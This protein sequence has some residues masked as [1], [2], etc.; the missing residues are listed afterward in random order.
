MHTLWDKPRRDACDC[1]IGALHSRELSLVASAVEEGASRRA[2]GEQHK[3]VSR[4]K[5]RIYGLCRRTS[6]SLARCGARL[7][8][9]LSRCAKS[10]TSP[11]EHALSTASRR[12]S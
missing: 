11:L 2:D 5:M 1:A 4:G 10:A 12:H 7:G 9:Y 3:S 6:L 8:I